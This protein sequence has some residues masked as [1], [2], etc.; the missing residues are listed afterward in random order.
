LNAFGFTTDSP[1]GFTTVTACEPELPFGVL[2]FSCVADTNVIAGERTPPKYTFAP[3]T[4]FVPVS[5]T[6]VPPAFGPLVGDRVVS[7]GGCSVGGG[8]VGGGVVGGGVPLVTTDTSFDAELN[9]H[10][11]S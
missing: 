6:N 11:L 1:L 2:A 3:L 8:V 5:V 9:R 7:V 4:K 10:V